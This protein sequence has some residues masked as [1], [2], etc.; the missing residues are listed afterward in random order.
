[1]LINNGVDIRTVQGCLGHSCATTT[2]NIYA[3][4]FQEAQAR[5]MDDVAKCILNRE[6]TKGA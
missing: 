1:M 2:L 5:A 4:T 3:H 6:K